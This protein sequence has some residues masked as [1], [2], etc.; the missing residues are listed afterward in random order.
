MTSRVL[1]QSAIV[2]GALADPTCNA[3][4]DTP[5]RHV[6]P[7]RRMWT[8]PLCGS[9]PIEL[10]EAADEEL[11]RD[12]AEA[13]RV[14]YVA[15]TRARD[16]LVAPVC[17]DQPIEG[18]LDVLR[19]VLYPPNGSRGNSDVAP[20]CPILAKTAWSTAGR[21]AIRQRWGQSVL[22]CTGR[23]PMDRR[24]SG[25]TRQCLLRKL[26]S[27]RRFGISASWR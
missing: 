27:T 13:I 18:W 8:E 21:R 12:R 2:M 10:L 1:R 9:A 5:S 17:G 14:A 11:R 6:D 20:D 15:A 19:P 4:R 16:L 23:W 7:H 3:A 24:S 25:G 22:A 26:K